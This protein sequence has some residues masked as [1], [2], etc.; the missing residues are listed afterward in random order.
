[1]LKLYEYWDFYVKLRLNLL[2]YVVRPNDEN[3]GRYKPVAK[4]MYRNQYVEK[5]TYMIELNE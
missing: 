1:V 4:V 2:W 3:I 5:I